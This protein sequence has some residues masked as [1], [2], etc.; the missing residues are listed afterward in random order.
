VFQS[1]KSGVITS[2][3]CGTNID[4]AVVATGYDSTASEPYYLVRNSWGTSWGD[5]G[6]VKIGMSSG[7]GICGINQYVYY[8]HTA[9][10]S[11]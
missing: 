11:G 3:A 4:H 7:K 5:K 2:A 8:P 6:Y 9:A 10:W 1:Y